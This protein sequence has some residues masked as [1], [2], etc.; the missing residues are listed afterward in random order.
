M[1]DKMA[2]SNSIHAI[3]TGDESCQEK[4]ERIAW[5]IRIG[6]GYRWVGIYDVTENEIAVI[7]WS[8]EGAPTVPRFPITQGLNG[9]AVAS[10]R[11]VIVNDVA[12]DPRYLTTFGNT[13]SEIIV[14][15]I[16]PDTGKVIGTIDV[17]SARKDAFGD[18]DREFLEACA[19]MI[20]PLWE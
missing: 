19:R 14:P 12:N 3:L 11:T 8:G 18:E 1:V 20:L 6:H 10:R 16:K 15:V 9:A 5:L 4:A 17:E 2:L 13:Q 7:G